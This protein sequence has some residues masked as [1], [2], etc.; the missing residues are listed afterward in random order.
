MANLDFQKDVLETS[1]KIPVLVD[2]WASWCGPCKVLGPVLEKL[3]EEASGTWKL[4]KVSTEEYP[5][6]AQEYRI[7]SIPAVKLFS[8]GKEIAEFIG[9][10][11]EVQVRR[12]LDEH[13]P[14]EARRLLLEANAANAAGDI[15]KAKKLYR[16][17][18]ELEAGNEEA[19]VKLALNELGSDAEAARVLAAEI[20]PE[21]GFNQEAETVRV[22]ARLRLQSA[23]I[24]ASADDGPAWKDYVVG[25]EAFVAG[26]YETA[27]RNWIDAIVVD[28]S[29]DSDGPRKACVAIFAWLGQQHE[30]T[31]RYHRSFTSALF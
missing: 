14:T 28:K 7:Q 2:F 29:I 24:S 31:Q 6:L 30:L 16:K 9:A 17:I 19:R 3:S 11:P 20:P 23:E 12:W 10:L 22:L 5:A 18:L 13:L 8:A 21:S 1:K 27:I 4:V 15:K 25:I 26:D